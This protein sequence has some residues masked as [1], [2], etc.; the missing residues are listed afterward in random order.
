MFTYLLRILLLWW[1]LTVLF[2]W[3]GK[4]IAP[5]HNSE[6]TIHSTSGDKGSDVV[7][8]GKIEDAEFE[9]MDDS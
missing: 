6:Q 7:H 8:S 5:S 4:L 1:I 2:K 9:E 3:V